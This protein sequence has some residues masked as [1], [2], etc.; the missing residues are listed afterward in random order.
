MTLF[1]KHAGRGCNAPPLRPRD[2]APQSVAPDKQRST[3]ENRDH[4]GAFFHSLIHK[5]FTKLSG[6]KP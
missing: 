5:K 4:R 1:D 2:P 6:A 3:L